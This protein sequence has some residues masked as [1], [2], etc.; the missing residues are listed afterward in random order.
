MY[1]F[2][3]FVDFYNKFSRNTFSP[4]NRSGRS[5]MLPDNRLGIRSVGLVRSVGRSVGVR[6]A[7]VRSTGIRSLGGRSVGS[8][9]A[10]RRWS[11]LSMDTRSCIL[12]L[13]TRSA[14]RRLYRKVDMIYDTGQKS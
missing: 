1:H 3:L 4:D 11:V 14:S 6:S 5:G 10:E 13:A 9:S 12:S 2:A 7:G 8:R